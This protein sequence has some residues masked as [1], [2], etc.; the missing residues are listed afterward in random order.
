MHGLLLYYD[1]VKWK[2]FEENENNIKDLF[3]CTDQSALTT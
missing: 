2:Q 1:H 3:K